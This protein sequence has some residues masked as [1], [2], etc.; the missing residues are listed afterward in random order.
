MLESAMV[1][2]GGFAV[3]YVRQTEING[4]LISSSNENQIRNGT[5]AESGSNTGSESDTR[6]GYPY[7]SLVYIPRQY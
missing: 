5:K 6:S 7:I 4:W 2:F 1:C 3:G